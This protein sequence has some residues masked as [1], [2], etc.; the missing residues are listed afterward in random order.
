VTSGYV[1]VG[2]CVYLKD[3]TWALAMRPAPRSDAAY[4]ALL[5]AHHRRSGWTVYRPVCEGCTACQP[6]RVPVATFQP[7]RSQRRALRRNAD[8]TLEV[9]PLQPTLEKVRLHD[10]F[11]AARFPG[12]EDGGFGTVEQYA[13]AFGSSP[14]TTREMRYRVGG[15]LIGLGIVD[16]L[17]DVV[18]SVY[19]FF[20][21]GEA[22]RSLGVYS[23]LREVDLA[24]ETGR[25]FVYLGYYIEAC[26]EMRYKARFRPCEVL[27][28]AGEWV[29]YAPPPASGAADD[30][31]AADP[32]DLP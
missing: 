31:D 32:S 3:R 12:K 26:R 22:R 7:S 24:R 23:A 30:G 27:T 14:V 25:R 17:P 6:L 5:E 4:R 11:V 15:R 28:Q 20:D 13:L 9:G 1:Q 19:F 10:A 8:V 2:P 21:P 16:L 18:S 29:P